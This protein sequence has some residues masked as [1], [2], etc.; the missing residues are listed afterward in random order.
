M[1]LV[2]SYQFSDKV[3]GMARYLTTFVA[4]ISRKCVVLTANSASA[5]GHRKLVVHT[6]YVLPFWEQVVLPF[7]CLRKSVATL[8]CPF[9]T[10]PLFLRSKTSLVLVIHDLIF[11][12]SI[13]KLPLSRSLYQNIGRFYRRCV[14]PR[15]AVRASVIV[16]VSEASKTQIVTKLG[17]AA[18][19]VIVLSNSLPMSWFDQS[20]DPINEKELAL[21]C[22]G[23]DSPSKNLV[24]L[25]QAFSKLHNVKAFARVKLYIVGVSEGYQDFLLSLA[26][27][28]GLHS[29]FLEFLHQISDFE[30]RL[31][32]KKVG[33][34]VVPSLF[35]GFGRPAIEALACGT[36]LACSNTSAL[37]EITGGCAWYFDPYCVENIAEVLRS[38]L[39]NREQCAKKVNSGLSWVSKF[40]ENTVGQSASSFWNEF[41]LGSVTKKI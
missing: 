5:Q 39:E 9:N 16:T 18:D 20:P 29:E 26:A 6:R 25:V 17:V 21:L 40:S 30:L 8:V 13:K 36:P 38:M 32:Y 31:L 22:V 28:S 11:M 10:A 4:P 2:D 3:R 7:I 24:R 15:A 12:E 34:V 27:A 1:I 23:G 37:P 41:E 33:G 19:K 35:E 14:V